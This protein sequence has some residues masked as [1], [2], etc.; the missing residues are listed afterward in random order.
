MQFSHF[1]TNEGLPYSHVNAMCQDKKGYIWI[2]TRKGLYRYDGYNIYSV[3]TEETLL[4]ALNNSQVND[5]Q[6]TSKGDV[7]VVMNNEVYKYFPENDVLKRYLIGQKPGTKLAVSKT[8]KIY[9]LSNS[10]LF[11]FDESKNLF[12]KSEF[13][14]NKNNSNQLFELAFDNNNRLWIVGSTTLF[15]MDLGT[16]NT[17][18]FDLRNNLPNERRSQVLDVKIDSENNLWIGTF[19]NG[20]LYYNSQ[21][22][23]FTPINKKTGYDIT[24]VRAFFE[25]DNKHIWIGGENGLRILDIKTQKIIQTLKQ[26]YTNILGLN[27]NAIYSIF[28][29]REHNM[30][31]GTYFGGINILYRDHQQFNYY[32][33]GYTSKN[34]SG[35]AVRQIIEDGNYL[36]MATEDGGLNKFNKTTKEFVHFSAGINS[37]S[38]NNIHSLLKD[39]KNNLW[40]GSFDGGINILNLKNNQWRYINTSNTPSIKSNMVFCFME[41]KDGIIYIGTINGLTLYDSNKNIF[42][43]IDHSI[44]NSCFIYNIMQDSEQNIWIAT[45]GEGLFCY[46]KK[47]NNFKQYKASDKENSLHENWITKVYEDTY[48][49]IWVGTDKSGLFLFN[50]HNETFKHYE[51]SGSCVSSLVEDNHKKLWISTEKGLLS[52]NIVNKKMDTYTKDDGLFSDQFNYNSALKTTEGELYFG[53]INGLISFNPEKIGQIKYQPNIVFVKLY[54]EGEEVTANM[55]DSPLK[56]SIEESSEIVLSH[57]QATSFSIEY[58]AIFYGHTKNIKYAVMM[59]GLE[60]AWNMLKDQRRVNYSKLPAGK[61]TFKVKTSTSNTD[62]NDAQIRTIDIVVRPPFYQSIWAWIIYILA[63]AG[64][65]FGILRFLRIRNNEKNQILFE[66]AEQAKAKEINRT[67]IDFF[68]NI[69]HELKTPLTLIVSP[70][71]RILDD[72][73]QTPVLKETLDVILRNAQRMTR[74]VDELMTFSK[75]EIGKEKLN[76]HKGNVLE[77]ISSLADIFTLLANEKGINYRTIVENNGEDVWFSIPN[78]EK[79]VFNLLSNSFKFTPQNGSVSIHA[80]LTEGNNERLLLEIVVSDTG[81]GIHKDYLERIFENY[82]QADPH[83]NIRG[84]G[85]G[86]SLTKRLVNLHKGTIQVESAINQGSK[87]TVLID[88]SDKAYEKEEKTFEILDKDFFTNYNFITVEKSLVEKA[89]ELLKDGVDEIRSIL[90]V[91]DNDELRKFLCDIFK[92]KYRIFSAE[93]GKI[94]LDIAQKEYPD[95]IVSDVMMPEMNGFELCKRIKADFSTCHIPVILLTAKTGTDDKMEGYDMGAD[96]Y[97]EKPFNSQLLEMQVQNI[98]RTRLNNIQTFKENPQ[99]DISEIITNERDSLFIKDLNELINLNLDNQFFSISDITKSLNVSRTLLHIKC[100]SLIDNSVTDYLK[101]IRMNKA[102][103]LLKSGS[104]IS[105]TAYAVGYSDPGYFSKVFKKHFDINPSVFVKN[106]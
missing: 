78:I 100:K 88:V 65:T 14:F 2:G 85:I 73:S 59:E 33:P 57:Q 41:D 64:A 63:M 12:D 30:W 13:D 92:D 21:T 32:A 60:K 66:K 69:S 3:R 74:I 46:N 99:N 4:S 106:K 47:K 72:K 27:D 38:N 77:F 87:F 37:I 81:E 35:K 8:D 40:M 22:E 43:P 55:P 94:A 7:W 61:Y 5:I 68:T 53:T 42:F 39:N 6:V 58:A 19:G 1:S 102:K 17:A 103:E 76:L 71:Q 23:E 36:W 18:Q 28:Q 89:N 34:V 93:N 84:S 51:V 16:N 31:I 62:W 54:I 20:I 11:V 70:L 101:E 98:I 10:E 52:I 83:S 25:D 9:C 97:I 75:I 49:N 26:D 56:K 95:L 86:L 44:L 67:K 50:K 79:I 82:Y 29:D 80:R 90:L 24:I 91:E 105:E 104:N 96:F 45:R 48:K 15:R